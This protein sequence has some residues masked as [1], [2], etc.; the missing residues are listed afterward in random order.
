MPLEP[1]T[2][3]HVISPEALAET[4]HHLQ[5]ISVVAIDTE[6]DSLHH[7]F[8]K[9]C[10]IQITAQHRNFVI[11]PLVGLDLEP[12]MGLLRHKGLIIHGADY[13]LRM[14]RISFGFE[15]EGEVFDTM[16]AAQLLGYPQIGLQALVERFYHIT[17]PKEGQKWDWSRRPLKPSQLEYAATDTYFLEEITSNLEAEL[18]EKDRRE[19]HREACR[20]VVEAARQIRE[21]DPEDTWRIK[22]YSGLTPRGLALLKGFWQWRDQQAQA[23]DLPPFRILNNQIIFEIIAWLEEHPDLDLDGCPCLPRNCKGRRLGQLQEIVGQ[24]D[25]SP[26]A[27]WPS[28]RRQLGKR[29]PRDLEAE[30]LFRNLRKAR[31]R[32]AEEMALDPSILAPK[33]AVAS[34]AQARPRTTEKIG[35]AGEL[36]YWQANVLAPLWLPLI[37]NDL[38]GGKS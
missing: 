26:P 38:A 12:L 1:K 24:V 15:P 25:L 36:M 3:L 17:I 9:V 13:D 7:Y 5:S 33:A 6:A 34:V 4:C 23:A 37:K 11:D 10:L 2:F 22:G 31:D 16:L 14:L 21:R 30:K 35:L 8:E 27:E 29:P 20:K 32:I 28:S 18:E 19:W